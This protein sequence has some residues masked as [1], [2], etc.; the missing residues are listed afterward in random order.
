MGAGK[1]QGLVVRV[2][3]ASVAMMLGSCGAP[4]P[5][6]DRPSRTFP[7]PI[8]FPVAATD[9]A[10]TAAAAEALKQSAALDAT[11][12]RLAKMSPELEAR[13]PAGTGCPREPGASR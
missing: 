8:Q 5:A 7:V 6:Q 12:G 3:L 4:Q 11:C 10:T 9:A 1:R 13:R 2:V